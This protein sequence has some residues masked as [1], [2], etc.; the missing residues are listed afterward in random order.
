MTCKYGQ[1]LLLLLIA[2]ISAVSS[3]AAQ[4]CAVCPAEDKCIFKILAVGDS[5]TRGAVPSAA[6]AHPYSWKMTEVLRS[7]ISARSQNKAS[8]QVTIAGDIISIVCE[9]G[10]CTVAGY[11]TRCRGLHTSFGSQQEKSAF[12][13]SR[14]QRELFHMNDLPPVKDFT[15][16]FRIATAV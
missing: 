6:S 9:V 10:I 15:L 3:Q 8:V 2:S 12:Q 7:R 5:L 13:P 11:A 16:S 1:Q 14:S 4:G